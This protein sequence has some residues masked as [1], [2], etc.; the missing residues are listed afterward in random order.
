MKPILV[1]IF[2]Y[3]V[4]SYAVMMVLGYLFA[5]GVLFKLAPKKAPEEDRSSLNRPQVWDLFIVMVIS[6]I[7]GSKIGHVLFEAPGHKDEQGHAI[8]SLWELL[9]ADPLHWARLGEPGYVW[10]GGMIGALLIAVYYFRRRPHLNAWLY[11]DAFAPAIMVGAAVGRVGCFMAG[12]CYG[13]ETS[14]PWGVHFPGLSGAR[15]P[16]QLYDATIAVVLGALLM[17][18]F[19]RR[20]FDGENIAILLMS[21]PVLRGITEIFRGDPERGTFGPFSTSQV[22]SVPLFVIGLLLYLRLSKK[23]K[24]SGEQ[25]LVAS[26]A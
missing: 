19:G 20:R 17:W 2:D 8:N 11:A 23:K 13:V 26:E 4:P 24:S 16:T 7:L 1:R 14:L 12:C 25:S 9:K 6:S 15:H 22:L 21:Y 10:Y 3:G 5:L 18:R